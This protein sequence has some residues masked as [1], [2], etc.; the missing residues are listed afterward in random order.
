[1]SKEIIGLLTTSL[2]AILSSGVAFLIA[3]INHKTN[4]LKIKNL[5][6]VIE[7]NTCYFINCP[8]CGRKIMLANQE[9][10]IDEKCELE[11]KENKEELKKKEV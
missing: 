10:K 3:F 11:K 8:S 9:I 4:K 5:E 7:H 6:D 2:T 1:M